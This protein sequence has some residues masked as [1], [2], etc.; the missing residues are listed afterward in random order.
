M[1]KWFKKE[2]SGEEQGFQERAEVPGS[3]AGGGWRSRRSQ[4]VCRARAQK[5]DSAAWA[6]ACRVE[7]GVGGQD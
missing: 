2:E 5:V 4:A 7:E 3:L 6:K 1:G